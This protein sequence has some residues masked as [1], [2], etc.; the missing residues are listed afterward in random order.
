MKKVSIEGRIGETTGIIPHR[1]GL[2]PVWF[3]DSDIVE[4]IEMAKVV[5]IT[6]AKIQSLAEELY[7]DSLGKQVTFCEEIVW[8]IDKVKL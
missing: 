2:Y 3:H 4:F 1:N 7:P 8:F 6:D 5:F